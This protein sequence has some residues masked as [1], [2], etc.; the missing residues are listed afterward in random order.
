MQKALTG[1]RPIPINADVSGHVKRQAIITAINI[2][3]TLLI[4][5][6][7]LAF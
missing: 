1:K 3:N 4:F 7:H 2:E 6:L 5:F